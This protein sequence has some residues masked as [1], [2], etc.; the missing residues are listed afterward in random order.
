MVLSRDCSAT[1]K[2]LSVATVQELKQIDLDRDDRKDFDHVV[3]ALEV[4]RDGAASP[5]RFYVGVLEGKR[6]VA[7]LDEISTVELP[8][9]EEERATWISARR[10]WSLEEEFRFALR[11]RLNWLFAKPGFD[12]FAWFCNED[13]DAICTVAE[14][15]LAALRAEHAAKLSEQSTASLTGLNPGHQDAAV[16]KA[17]TALRK[18]EEKAKPYLDERS[19]RAGA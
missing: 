2:A 14:A 13:L 16:Q 3:K 18:L 15:Q 11:A 8:S 19:R 7:H 4:V 9:A 12:D 1:H 17:E 5:D 6:Y 10:V